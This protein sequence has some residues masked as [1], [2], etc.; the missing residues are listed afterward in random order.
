MSRTL[1]RGG[2]FRRGKPLGPHDRY[3][4]PVFSDQYNN[5]YMTPTNTAKM[6]YQEA[7]ILEEGMELFELLLEEDE[8]GMIDAPAVGSTV[9]LLPNHKKSPQ[10]STTDPTS[11]V[12]YTVELHMNQTHRRRRLFIFLRRKLR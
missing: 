4:Q 7:W 8:Q 2:L 3:G 12:A 10:S 11:S 5:T 6:Y 9:F 1:Y